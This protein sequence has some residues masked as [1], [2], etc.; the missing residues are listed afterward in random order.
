M[1]SIPSGSVA[2]LDATEGR[3]VT[4]LSPEP[5][6]L[7][8]EA[9]ETARSLQSIPLPSSDPI[10][11]SIDLERFPHVASYILAAL[12]PC[13]PARL[14]NLMFLADKAHVVQTGRPIVGG[15]YVLT[16]GQ[17]TSVEAAAILESLASDQELSS[18]LCESANMKLLSA[19]VRPLH[20]ADGLR[21]EV[22]G[23]PNE[24]F[25]SV[26]DIEVLKRTIATHGG[27]NTNELSTMAER[28]PA[29]ALA[30]INGGKLDYGWFFND[31]DPEEGNMLIHLML[32]QRA[33]SAVERLKA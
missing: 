21:L 15:S 11:F 25:L 23:I 20:A 27:F 7:E 6:S 10:S 33:R 24:R 13:E 28:E 26:S 22:I 31:Q 14:L 2:L 16:K 3:D 19:Y 5:S 32:T 8:M 12:G 17:P 29:V 18:G 1:K 30:R 4:K 9:Q